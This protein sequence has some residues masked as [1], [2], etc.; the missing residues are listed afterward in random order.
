MIFSL[1][2]PSVLVFIVN[3]LQRNGPSTAKALRLC[4]HIPGFGQ[5]EER[6]FA[7]GTDVEPL[8]RWWGASWLS[9]SGRFM[10]AR[11]VL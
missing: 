8:Q 5:R 10:V 6:S 11:L 7:P 9:I 3:F 1:T 2:D 4:I